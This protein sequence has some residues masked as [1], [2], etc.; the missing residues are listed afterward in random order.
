MIVWNHEAK[1][2][3]KSELVRRGV[4]R[5]QL[6]KLLAEIGVAETK[7][8]IDSKIA[9]GTFSATFLLQCLTAIGCK[10]ISVNTLNEPMRQNLSSGSD[11]KLSVFYNDKTDLYYVDVTDTI[12]YTEVK[13]T[14]ISLFTGAG[15][16][17][18]GLELAGFRTLVCVEND[19]DCVAT[20]KYNRPE[21]TIF[22][23]KKKTLNSSPIER[24]AGDIRDIEPEE[25]LDLANLKKG[26]AAIVAGG[27]P[28]Q[29]FS[30]IGKGK[31][32][33]DSK[34]GDLFLEFVRMVKGI[35][36]KAFIFE[37]VSGITQK[38]HSYVLEYMISNFSGSDYGL[39][40]AIVNAANYGIAQKRERF[41]LIGIKHV[42]NPAFPLPTHFKNHNAFENFMRG[43]RIRPPIKPKPW[44]TLK[45]VLSEIPSDYE[46][47]DDYA[48][49][50]LS[51]KIIERMH[52]VKQGQNFKVL[53]MNLRP[54]CWKTG[55]HQGQDTFGR[56][57]AEQPS[58]TIRTAAY[59]PTKGMYI[60][61]FENRGLNTVEMAAIQGFPFEW[62]FRCSNKDRITLVS[63]GKQIG[64]AVPPLLAKVIA[65]A[66]KKQLFC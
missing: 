24:Q 26:E 23:N 30:N 60:H 12:D 63:G 10:S 48:V 43:F 28:C 20:L 2:L 17:D 46:K 41:F 64:N 54:D 37:N 16:L 4:S 51:Q 44:L 65:E 39:S 59:N 5:E 66:I 19:L 34:N 29:P 25:I 7:A 42:E 6:V 31:G 50:N 18:I 49:M 57:Y 15:G 35:Q 58:V 14:V 3:L 40:H 38:K 27:A 32:H 62:I 8:S 61:P 56:L 52:Y 1:F 22:E 9:R 45:R 13:P 55:K 36:P 21:W 11:K 33:N 47:R 53:P